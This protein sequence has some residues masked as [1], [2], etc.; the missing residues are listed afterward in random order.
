MLLGSEGVERCYGLEGGEELVECREKQLEGWYPF[1]KGTDIW[2][3]GINLL[4][5]RQRQRFKGVYARKL[6]L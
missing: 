1:R 2:K 3:Q 5:V 4:T 6:H